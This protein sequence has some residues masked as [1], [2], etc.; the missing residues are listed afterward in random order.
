M[1]RLPV[2]EAVLFDVYDTL[3][4]NSPDDWAVAFDAICREQGLPCTGRELWTM[5]KRHEVGFREARTNLTDP[6]KSPPFKTYEMAWAECFE[7]VFRETGTRG[8]PARAARRSVE[9]M[10]SRPIFPDTRPA[11]EAMAGK[12][13]LGVFSNADEAFLQP[14]LANAGL[15]FEFVASSESA[16][17]YKPSPPAFRH[18]IDSMKIDPA[19][20][21]YV[22]DQL[23]D[24]VLGADAVGLTTVWINRAGAAANGRGP[25]PDATISDLRELLP[26]L[27]AARGGT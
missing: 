25:T 4:L 27:D 6:A 16:R 18:L 11:L 8:D 26:L 21:W 15:T 9:H 13:R 12:V 24:D 10:S 5:W 3:F 19:K 1:T 17:V 22:G 14:L 7:R 2:P 23:F 20:A